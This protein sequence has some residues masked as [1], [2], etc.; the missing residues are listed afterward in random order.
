MDTS[1]L[2]ESKARSANLA[3]EGSNPGRGIKLHGEVELIQGV[4]CDVEA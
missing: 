4:F 1:R 3:M 2:Q